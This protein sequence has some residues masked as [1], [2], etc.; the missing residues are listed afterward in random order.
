MPNTI[1]LSLDEYERLLDE[2]H[3]F[4]SMFSL[5]YST[6]LNGRYGLTISASNRYQKNL[7]K[8]IFEE[9]IDDDEQF[10]KIMETYTPETSWENSICMYSGDADTAGSDT[11]E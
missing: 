10:E 1:T 11:S 7:L 6:W 5:H 8:K 2:L 9:E 3:T 4:R